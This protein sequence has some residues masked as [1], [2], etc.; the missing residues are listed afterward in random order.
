VW[1]IDLFTAEALEMMT[2]QQLEAAIDQG[3]WTE[4]AGDPK[5]N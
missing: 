1:G 2:A 3:L 4:A 5:W